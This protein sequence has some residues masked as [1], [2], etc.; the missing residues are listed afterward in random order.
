MGER[1][2]AH[3]S[4][5]DFMLSGH[6]LIA[7]L[8]GHQLIAC[9]PALQD[10]EIESA[11]RMVNFLE[12]ELVCERLS[13]EGQRAQ[14]ANLALSFQ[15]SVQQAVASTCSMISESVSG[16]ALL[17][18]DVCPAAGVCACLVQED[19]SCCARPT[20]CCRSCQGSPL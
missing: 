10:A 19:S 4:S 18:P 9:V 5:N 12:N 8:L 13:A 1:V 14:A 2:S 11:R 16:C 7:L 3:W 20:L 17:R 6:N 15:R